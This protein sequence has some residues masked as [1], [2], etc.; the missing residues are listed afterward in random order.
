LTYVC[1]LLCSLEEG[2]EGASKKE[3]N[4]GADTQ[5]GTGKLTEVNVGS[6]AK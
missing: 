6:V 4:A 1:L 5:E 3:T 2:S